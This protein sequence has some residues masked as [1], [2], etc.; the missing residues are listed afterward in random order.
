MKLLFETSYEV[1]NKVGGIYTV[2][3]SKVESLKDYFDRHVMVGPWFRDRMSPEFMQADTVDVPHEIQKVFDVLAKKEIYCTY[4]H[5]KILGEPEVILIDFNSL[6]NPAVLNSLKTDYWNLFKVDSMFAGWDF[7]EPLC[8]STAVGMLIEEFA[9]QNSEEY[10]SIIAQ[11]HEWMTGF[12]GLYLKKQELEG[13]KTN[14]R[15]I[16]TTHATM[17]GRSLVANGYNLTQLQKSKEFD[18]L[19]YAKN[20]GVVE[21]FTAEYA[22]ANN[23]D[24]FTTVSELTKQEAKLQ[25]GRTPKLTVNGIDTESFLAG[26][27][28]FFE[29]MRSK[30]DLVSL[31]DM[32]YPEEDFENHFFAYTSGRPEYH[33][34][35]YDVIL[36]ALSELNSRDAPV[37]FFFLVPWQN[38]GIKKDYNKDISTHYLYDEE[39]HPITIACN[40]LGINNE[41]R[42]KVILYP[43]YLGTRE[44]DLFNNDYYDVISGF[45]LGV[46]PSYYE[47][48]GYTPLESIAVGVPALITDSTGFGNYLTKKKLSGIDILKQ[49]NNLA[50]NISETISKH[51]LYDSRK[52]IEASLAAQDLAKK[53]DW[54]EFVKNYIKVYKI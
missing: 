18:A 3:S 44:D 28:L 37:V 51:M 42:L 19:E 21:K 17:L 52:K 43:C 39:N 1:C 20:I 12:G 47:P 48:W 53:C 45:D 40:K 22:C 29:Q 16:F 27:E 25:F 50:L 6:A 35:G 23:H 30:H 15:T 2:I 49:D 32:L 14:V 34:K 10:D 4:G 9:K 41:G 36:D 7:N 26:K 13:K 33:N 24:E 11:F 8:F 46:F 5:W 38:Y 31:M 54:K